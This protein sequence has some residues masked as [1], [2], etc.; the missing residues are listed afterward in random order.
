[1]DLL[2]RQEREEGCRDA[3]VLAVA[4]ALDAQGGQA[5]GLAE[6]ALHYTDGLD[7]GERYRRLPSLQEPAPDVQEVPVARE[8]EAGVR[9]DRPTDGQDP[10]E[11][12]EDEYVEQGG[13]YRARR[14][15][16]EEALGQVL[17]EDVVE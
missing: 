12:A 1:M 15:G 17:R 7:A 14:E 3:R 10:G 16:L 6:E 8:R 13:G 4:G 2:A 9:Q 11:E 5:E